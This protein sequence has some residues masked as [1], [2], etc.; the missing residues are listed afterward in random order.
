MDDPAAAQP[1]P[2]PGQRDSEDGR[3][4]KLVALR[5]RLHEQAQAMRTSEDWARCLCLAARLPG[6]S[7]ANIL[8]ISA[9]RPGAT[10]LHGYDAWHAVGRQVR[11]QEKGIAIFSVGRSR[12]E[13]Q[14]PVP[15][16]RDAERVGSEPVAGPARHLKPRNSDTCTHT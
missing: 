12:S 8:L 11:R 14:D 2:I 5:L 1:P 7:F 16:W 13:S 9:Q 15:S 4:H 10:L 3:Q 6:E